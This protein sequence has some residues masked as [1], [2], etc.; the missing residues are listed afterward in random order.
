MVKKSDK[1]RGG[2]PTVM[3]DD[4][5]QKLKLAYSVGSTNAEACAYAEIAE[6]S[7]Y[8]HLSQNP[9][10][11]EKIERWKQK[12]ILKAKFELVKGLEGNPEL[13]L[14]YLERKKKD[15]FSTRVESDITAKGLQIIVSS[16]EDKEMLEDL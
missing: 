2:R 12:P 13:A 14:K 5:L 3:T 8:L 16:E 4:V 11:S 9:E 10:F 7:L 6:S 15:E 1:S